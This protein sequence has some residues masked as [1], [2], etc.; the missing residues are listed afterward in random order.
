M[1][2]D[3]LN[4]LK[5]VLFPLCVWLVGRKSLYQYFDFFRCCLL[6]HFI[7]R[8]HKILIHVHDYEVMGFPFFFLI[9]HH[10]FSLFMHNTI[11]V[12]IQQPIIRVYYCMYLWFFIFLHTHIIQLIYQSLS[13]FINWIYL[14]VYHI[15]KVIWNS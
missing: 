11:L 2:F 9:L 13:I 14:H 4:L 8:L 5:Y 15:K 7:F 6:V 3:L 12:L 1:E 10:I